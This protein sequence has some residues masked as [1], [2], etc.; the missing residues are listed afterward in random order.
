EL[1]VAGVIFAVF[2]TPGT[3]TVTND[4]NKSVCEH[5]ATL[6]EEMTGSGKMQTCVNNS[7]KS[8]TRVDCTGTVL[9]EH[10]LFSE[11]EIDYCFGS[12]LHSCL[13]PPSM[14]FYLKIPSKKYTL[15]ERIRHDTDI[16]IKEVSYP[17]GKIGNVHP[18][19]YFEF[20]RQEDGN[21]KF[22]VTIKV[23][24]VTVAGTS[25]FVNRLERTLI[26]E[27]TIHGTTCSK[28]VKDTRD[29]P[30]E[31]FTKAEC[32]AEKYSPSSILPSGVQIP[33]SAT[34][35]K[36]CS[37]SESLCVPRETCQLDLPKPK[38]VCKT[39]YTLSPKGDVCLTNSRYG[40]ACVEEDDCGDNEVCAPLP[41]RICQCRKGLTYSSV[42]HVCV[43]PLHP[44]PG[45]G[46]PP[47]PKPPVVTT[48]APKSGVNGTS[49]A[50]GGVS[51]FV[52]VKLPIIL[53]CVL[54]AFVLSAVTVWG[55]IYLRKRGTQ[56]N[57][58]DTALNMQDDSTDA[59]LGDMDDMNM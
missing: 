47:G 15:S 50:Q 32:H 5:W 10:D 11:L 42:H 28:L 37:F 18:V 25:M 36:S 48:Q 54:G 12:E 53:G 34:L 4:P 56:R 51:S 6:A 33:P 17:A 59:L 57:R 7:T 9:Y 3:P 39:E 1:V 26:D 35:S 46:A 14:D 30:P 19:L 41:T 27:E 22:S 31:E 24:L 40:E 23:K 20:E 49:T 2:L 29:K 52:K 38:C 13:D 44:G 45:T 55:M 58:L 16:D 8:C 21:F 43:A